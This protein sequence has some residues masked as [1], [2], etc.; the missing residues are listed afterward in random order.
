[1]R[2]KDSGVTWVPAE[3][4]EIEMAGGSD[5]ISGVEL[6]WKTDCHEVKLGCAC[7]LQQVF[8]FKYLSASQYLCLRLFFH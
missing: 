6:A 1:M 2:E 5:E 7:L 3:E 4:N 8:S